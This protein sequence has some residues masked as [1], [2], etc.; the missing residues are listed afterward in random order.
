[1]SFKEFQDQNPGRRNGSERE[2][3]EKETEEEK[4]GRIQCV[5]RSTI[6]T[7]AKDCFVDYR[8]WKKIFCDIICANVSNFIL[9][10]HVKVVFVSRQ[11]VP[12]LMLHLSSLGLQT[13]HSS[14]THTYVHSADQLTT[15]CSDPSLNKLRH[16]HEMVL[17]TQTETA[18]SNS[19]QGGLSEIQA[20]G[21][22]IALVI[23]GWD[24][25]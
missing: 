23:S 20:D 7:C 2:G 8:P 6:R 25:K 13:I 4:S 14:Y 5:Q 9:S 18:S 11:H 21:H 17:K 19:Y 15:I 16:N 24:L 3:R 12:G 10:F 22:W 1:M